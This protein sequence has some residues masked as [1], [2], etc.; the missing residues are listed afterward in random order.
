ME[1]FVGFDFGSSN[2]ALQFKTNQSALPLTGDDLRE[3]VAPLTVS[4]TSE[5]AVARLAPKSGADGTSFQSFHCQK[6]HVARITTIPCCNLF[7]VGDVL[8]KSEERWGE[9]RIEY[10]SEMLIHGLIAG[11][12]YLG[13]HPL[14]INGVFSYPLTFTEGRLKKF[15]DE[16]AIVLKRV[17]P[18]TGANDKLAKANFVDEATAG[19]ASLGQPQARELVVTADLGGGTL[20][21]SAGRSSDGPEKDQIGSSDAGGAL[22]LRRDEIGA[23]MQKY[24]DTMSRIARGEVDR[25]EWATL[26]PH[27]DRYYQLLFIFLETVLG[28]Y[29]IRRAKHDPVEKVSIY[30]LG[31]GWRFHELMVNSMQLNPTKVAEEEIVRLTKNLAAAMQARHGVTV[32]ATARIVKNPKAAVAEG[33]LRV[34]TMTGERKQTDVSPRLPLGVNATNGATETP[35][36]ELFRGDVA[37]DGFVNPAVDFDE[38]ELRERL[39]TGNGTAWSSAPFDALSLRADMQKKEY[40][41]QGGGFT[42]G[43]MQVLIETQWLK[44][45]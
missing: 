2:T 12:K 45:A 5:G 36:H 30:P 44:L 14:N 43:P 8:F 26:R 33:C 29:L 21:I 41:W 35:W 37:K 13:A 15:T 10:I 7:T 3:L 19:V 9:V 18:F 27:I 11:S 31:N 20:D 38:Q 23:D 16:L 39:R 22:F 40:F 6:H 42:R 17:A 28:S 1:F 24:V 32:E 34:A 25:A 4:T